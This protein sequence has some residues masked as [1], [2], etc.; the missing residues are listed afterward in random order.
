[1]IIIGRRLYVTFSPFIKYLLLLILSLSLFG[2][3]DKPVAAPQPVRE[4]KVITV[5]PNT[6]DIKIPRLAQLQSSKEVAVVARVSGFLDKVTYKEGAA[7]KKGDIMFVMD[8]RPFISDLNAAKGQLASAKARLWT[9]NANLKRIKPLA[10]AD[11]MSQSDLDTAIGEQRAAEASVY[12]AKAAVENAKLNLS[13]TTIT[14]PLA[15]LTGAAFQREG[16]YLNSQ[17]ESANI[18]YVA[19]LDPIWVNFALSQNELAQYSKEKKEGLVTAPGEE[20]YTFEIVLADGSL[21]PHTGYL[22]FSSPIFDKSTGTV[23]IRAVVP[24]P[25]LSLRPGMFVSAN[26]LGAKR[27]NAIVVPQQAVQQRSTGPIVYVVNNKGIVEAQPI[28]VGQWLGDGWIVEDGL[29]GGEAL[30][31]DGFKTTQPGMKVKALHYIPKKKDSKKPKDA[32]VSTSSSV[33]H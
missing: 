27:P 5:A 16:A 12:S 30:M 26:L 9:A 32:K 2:C 20:R 3:N 14:A 8:K 23:K 4:V 11:A 22:D 33:K 6:V 18:S 7:V 25:D 31:V 15:G 28:I 19:Q 17:G 29:S 10:E 13:Y 21:Y 1:M 24:N